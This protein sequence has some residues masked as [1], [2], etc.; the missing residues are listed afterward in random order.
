MKLDRS[1]VSIILALI[2]STI[3]AA[4]SIAVLAQMPN[5]PKE[6]TV[7]SGDEKGLYMLG[8]GVAAGLALIGAAYGLGETCVA[9]I[10]A[11][12]EKPEL[13]GMTFAYVVFVEA[14][15]IYGLVIVFMVLG[16]L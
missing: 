2:V 9:A 15:G 6:S 7:A 5:S 14:I 8:A 16:K 12:T 13:F 4:G 10:S 11:I 3:L 1:N